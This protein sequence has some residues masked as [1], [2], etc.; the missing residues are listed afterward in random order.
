MQSAVGEK[1][2]AR[3]LRGHHRPVHAH[4]LIGKSPAMQKIYDLIERITDISSNVLIT[5]ESGTGKE[6][7]AR[8]VHREA[9]DPG[10]PFVAVNLGAIPKDLVE[11][12]L[13]GHEKGAFTGA[14]SSRVGRFETAH[15]GTLFIDEVAS[16]PMP[17]CRNRIGRPWPR[18]VASRV[19]PLMTIDVIAPLAAD[20]H[21]TP[22]ASSLSSHCT[23]H[24]AV[25]RSRPDDT[26][27]GEERSHGGSRKAG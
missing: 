19:T 25:S 23:T 11:S 27:S 20:M 3:G 5:G 17:G 2:A 4:H 18:S 15:R 12:T 24:G 13:F 6:L 8:M 9:G 10:R 26:F 7:L 21:N 22:R 16:M 1:Q 14:I